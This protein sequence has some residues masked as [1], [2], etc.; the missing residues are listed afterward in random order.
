[1]VVSKARTTGKRSDTEVMIGVPT[2]M[3]IDL[4]SSSNLQH[5]LSQLPGAENHLEDYRHPVSKGD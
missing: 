2:S 5:N 4:L 3:T 1:M